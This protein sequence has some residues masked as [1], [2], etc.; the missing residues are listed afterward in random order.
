MYALSV[1]LTGI[2]NLH[3]ASI[4]DLLEQAQ[5]A[6]LEVLEARLG[7]VRADAVDAYAAP[8]QAGQNEAL[9]KGDV[10]AQT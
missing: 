7:G 1:L 4:S 8:R 6:S 3:D 9:A 5:E 10:A 2:A